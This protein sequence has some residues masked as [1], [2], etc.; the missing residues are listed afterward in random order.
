MDASSLHAGCLWS[1]YKFKKKDNLY[2]LWTKPTWRSGS[3]CAVQTESEDSEK[4]DLW[5]TITGC[6]SHYLLTQF[7]HQSAIQWCYT[8]TPRR[9]AKISTIEL[10]IPVLSAWTVLFC[11]G[12]LKVCCAALRYAQPRTV[13][14]RGQRTELSV[15]S[16]ELGVMSLEIDLSVISITNVVTDLDTIR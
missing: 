1:L 4:C 5:E 6:V 3:P 9:N 15:S 16:T 10:K 8:F 14:F 12:L 11:I 2:L 13:F 7:V